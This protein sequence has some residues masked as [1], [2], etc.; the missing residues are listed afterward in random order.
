MIKYARLRPLR[1]FEV[2]FC[3]SKLNF[4]KYALVRYF[5]C[6]E[7][8]PLS[9]LK[10]IKTTIH[11][12]LHDYDFNTIDVCLVLDI[13]RMNGRQKNIYTQAETLT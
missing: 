2:Y 1:I 8:F 4:P 13:E 11:I 10:R 3:S 12:N 7:F 6:K 9:V 5:Q